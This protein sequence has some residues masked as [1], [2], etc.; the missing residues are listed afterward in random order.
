MSF[1]GADLAATH[2]AGFGDEGRAAA[3]L[4]LPLL[5]AGARVVELGCGS[6]ASAAPLV[7]AGHAVQ[8]FDVAPAMVELARARVPGAAFAVGSAL[9]APLG[10]PDAVLAVSEVLTYATPEEAPDLEAFAARAAAALPAGGLLLLD[11]L[12]TEAQR[13]ARSVAHGDGWRVE[14][15]ARREGDRLVRRI[16]TTRAGRRSEETHVQGLLEPGRAA[17]VLCAHGFEPVASLD[18]YPGREPRSGHDIQLA[19]RT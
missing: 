9:T 6:G 15:E 7:A 11:V 10:R 19:R 3:A 13:P 12:T 16:V 18:A 5:P 2:D 14:V 17:A 1:Y 4:V 8:G